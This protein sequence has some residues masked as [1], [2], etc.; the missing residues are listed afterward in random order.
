MQ[1]HA[2]IH[3]SPLAPDNICLQEPW[4]SGR[5]QQ[6][7][8]QQHHHPAAHAASQYKL[9]HGRRYEDSSDADTDNETE[10]SEDDRIRQS[11]AGIAAYPGQTL[12]LLDVQ[13]ADQASS[14]NRGGGGGGAA[15]SHG[16][17][18]DQSRQRHSKQ[19]STGGDFASA[20]ATAA[21]QKAAEFADR[22]STIAADPATTAATAA[23]T[24]TAVDAA[25]DDMKLATGA[26]D[27]R[28]FEEFSKQVMV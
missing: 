13:P 2:S 15:G 10:W 25:A 4:S 14:E 19:G 18:G 9:L 5:Q 8:Q 6:Q 12:P 22:I 24:S 16:S 21:S 11:S 3:Q 28:R 7:Q 1:G 17:S 23:A 27:A 20:A 26:F